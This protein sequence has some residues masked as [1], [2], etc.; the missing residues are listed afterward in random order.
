MENSHTPNVPAITLVCFTE[1]IT[2]FDLHCT[3]G[4]RGAPLEASKQMQLKQTL[5]KNMS[6]CTNSVYVVDQLA[7]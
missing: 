3:W 4:E 2:V 1:D 6:L 7:K 5:N